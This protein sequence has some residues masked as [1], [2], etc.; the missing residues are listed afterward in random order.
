MAP[1]AAID[2]YFAPWSGEGYLNAIDQAIHN[3]DYAAV[4]ISY[5]LAGEIRGTATN[6]GWP[7]LHKNVD[8]AFRD[9]TAVGIPVFVS[10]GDQGSSSLRGPNDVTLFSKTA[11]IAYPASSPYVTS[12]GGTQLYV[13][14]GAISQEVVWNELGDL[15]NDPQIGQ[16]YIGG[17]TTGGVSERYARVPS[18]QS[19]AGVTPQSANNPGTQGRGVP[20]VAGNAGASTGYLVSQPPGSSDPIAPVGGTSA[21]APMWA[22][23]MACVREGLSDKFNGNVPPFFFNDFAYAKGNTA[24]FRDIVGGRRL[25]YDPNTGEAIPGEFIAI[26]NNR[27]TEAD[28]NYANQGFDLCTGWGSPNG[29]ELLNQLQ[30]WLASRQG[31]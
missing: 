8:E 22:A 7:M 30:T 4:S 21:A 16:Y 29:N 19:S 28:G 1:K 26:G 13:E 9:A 20:D 14:N 15:Q 3:D 23:L 31:S 10:S 24:A 5:G 18:Y 12:V 17:A 6:P 25:T 2:V 11:H 27:C